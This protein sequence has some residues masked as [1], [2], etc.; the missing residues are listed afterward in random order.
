MESV[1]LSRFVEQQRFWTVDV[2]GVGQQQ[3][4]VCFAQWRAVRAWNE[5]TTQRNRS[6]LQIV[7]G[8]H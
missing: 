8:K 3:R 4:F 1:K 2:F 5:A 6:A 7:N